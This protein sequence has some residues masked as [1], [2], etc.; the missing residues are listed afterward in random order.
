MNKLPMPGTSGHIWCG[1]LGVKHAS[2]SCLSLGANLME[3][4]TF[5]M[6]LERLRVAGILPNRK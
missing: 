3:E 1:S 5:E 4:V 6:T 2:S